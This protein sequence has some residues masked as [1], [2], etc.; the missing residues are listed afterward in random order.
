VPEFVHGLDLSEHFYRD[1]I[2]PL[3]QRA[4]RSLARFDG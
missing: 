2:A 4:G 1:V 3:A